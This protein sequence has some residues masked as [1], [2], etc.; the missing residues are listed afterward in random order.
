MS[1]PLISV[2]MPAHNAAPFIGAAIHS[3]LAQ[4]FAGFELLVVDD[5]ST[6]ETRQVV[7]AVE[8]SRIRLFHCERALNAAGARNLALTEARG[9]IVAFLDADDLAEPERL[10]RQVATL[11]DTE[12]VASLIIP[13]DET[14][15]PHGSNFV[16]PLLSEE[17][18]ATLLFKNCLALSSVAVRRHT[19]SPFR[20]ELAPAE[21]YDL[22][23]RLAS[24]ARFAIIPQPLTRYRI[25]AGGVSARQP[26]AMRTAVAAI[27]RA[28]LAALG[29]IANME[30]L[31]LHA[32]LASWPLTAARASLL[33]A[34]AWLE[35]LLAA[36]AASQSFPNTPF[37][38]VVGRIWHTVCRD[39][40][41]L[42]LFAWTAFFGS[43]LHR[44]TRFTWRDHW[45][46]LRHTLPS[47]IRHR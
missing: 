8:D 40:W 26:D 2:I 1:N 23:T 20:P 7:A 11:R 45:A 28:Q 44:I 9:E 31:E 13:I 21:D 24:R 16:S 27:H 39:S 6:D 36:N 33:D 29:L 12:V 25:H 42:G 46:I 37:Q 38:R 32:R 15:A 3:V 5:A 4:S 10:E 30:E 17:I 18:P 14:G 35:S 34:Q 22:W 47:S 41:P 43:P 19:L